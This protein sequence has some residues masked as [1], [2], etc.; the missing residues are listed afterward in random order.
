M[1]HYSLIYLSSGES[2]AE[3]TEVQRI[4]N[5]YI[6]IYFKG[7]SIPYIHYDTSIES[8]V[9]PGYFLVLTNT[10]SFYLTRAEFEREYTTNLEEYPD[11]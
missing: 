9:K 8:T 1:S 4:P 11:G 2:A 7:A 6:A 10:D 3:V 5:G